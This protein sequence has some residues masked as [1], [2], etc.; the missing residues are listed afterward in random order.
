MAHYHRSGA[1]GGL[2]AL[3]L[4]LMTAA[5]AAQSP[6]DL[7]PKKYKD[8]GAINVGSVIDYPPYAWIDEATS[9]MRGLEIEVGQAV[10]E[11]LGIGW[12]FTNAKWEGLI[13]GVASER[14]DV[15]SLATD[16]PERQKIVTFI[17]YTNTSHA[18]II[19]NANAEKYPTVEAL[20][21]HSI[22]AL[23]GTTTATIA[24]EVAAECVQKGLP[25]LKVSLYTSV[26]DVD[27]ALQSGRDAAQIGSTEQSS[28]LILTG[29]QPWKVLRGNIKASP[30]GMYVSAGRR[31][32]AEAI[33]AAMHELWKE[34]RLKEI[35]ATY[36]LQ[37]SIIEPGI[38][39]ST[40]GK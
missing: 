14:Y 3:A 28:Y 2:A 9:K 31:D 24:E 26:P 15:G 23:K 40:G 17:G 10:G 35:A 33:Q 16:L 13:T 39:L 30:M 29:G 8:A 25:E 7:L 34:G 22:G 21:G 6:A 11:K 4:A 18:V 12:N 32:L 1:L 19:L 36:G 20:C 38:N 5:A 37:D 27:L